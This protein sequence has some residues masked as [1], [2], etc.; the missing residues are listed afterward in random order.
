MDSKRSYKDVLLSNKTLVTQVFDKNLLEP[1]EIFLKT[2]NRNIKDNSPKNIY[3]H[4][5][6]LPKK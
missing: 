3:K 2:R 5:R 6:L 1:I 4:R